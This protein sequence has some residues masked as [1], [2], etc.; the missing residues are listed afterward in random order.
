MDTLSSPYY[1]AMNAGTNNSELDFFKPLIDAT[2]PTIMQVLPALNSGGVERGTL[3][4]S[5]A[6]VSVGWN[7]IVVSNGGSMVKEL[8]DNGGV[9]ITLSVGSKNPLKWFKCYSRLQKIISAHD[10]DLIHARSRIP[11]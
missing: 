3:E 11:A 9:H 6:L 7:S 1:K 10:V 5:D 2:A 4:I 8:T